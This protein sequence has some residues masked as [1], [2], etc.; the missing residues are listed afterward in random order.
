MNHY[1]RSL[2]DHIAAIIHLGPQLIWNRLNPLIPHLARRH[3]R[4]VRKSAIGKFWYGAAIQAEQLLVLAEQAR[5][6]RL[7]VWRDGRSLGDQHKTG[8]LTGHKEGTPDLGAFDSFPL[9]W[10]GKLG[11]YFAHYHRPVKP[12]KPLTEAERLA[13]I[14]QRRLD[15][16]ERLYRADI[17]EFSNEGNHPYKAHDGVPRPKRP[18]HPGTADAFAHDW[19]RRQQVTD[20]W[21]ALAKKESENERREIRGCVVGQHDGGSRSD[22]RCAA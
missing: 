14:P 19:L 20:E 10:T 3:W 16:I 17:W 8:H 5:W 13:S 1:D 21:K 7:E 12:R 9:R 15:S 6:R 2:R 11:R 18:V 4:R 22:P